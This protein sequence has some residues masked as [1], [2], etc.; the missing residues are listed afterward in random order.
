MEV[1][2]LLALLPALA[3]MPALAQA[4][5]DRPLVVRGLS[6]EGNRA[7]D[8]Y[9][10]EIS[11][12]TSVSSFA[13]RTGLVRWIGI[14][15]KRYFNETEFR[16]DV[17]RLMLL[18][19]QSGYPRVH[20]DTIVRRSEDAVNIRFL[21]SEG[22]PIVVRSIDIAG[23]GDVVP[24]RDLLRDIPLAVGDPFNRF[25]FDASAD[26]IRA[27]FRDRGHPFAEVFRSFDVDE[28]NLVARVAFEV[29]PG[30]RAVV[31]TVLVEG[32]R[33]IADEVVRRM[34]P[35]RS[36]ALVRQSAL[37]EAQR[38]LY[39][40]GIF[41][42]VNVELADS[43]PGEPEDS[44]VAVR[45]QVSEGALNRVRI[46]AGYGTIDCFRALTSFTAQN[47]LG[48]GRALDLTAR[49]SK[50]GVGDPF[51][52]GLERRLLCQALEP[53]TASGRL[54]LNYNVSL[55]L[56]TPY[57]FSRRTSATLSVFAERHSEIQAYVREVVGGNLSLT[58]QTGWN[59]PLTLTYSLSRGSTEAEPATFCSF[60]LVCNLDDTRLFTK[61][62]RQSTLAIA[63]RRERTNSVVDPTRGN[64]VSAEI[65][66]SSPTIGSDPLIDF[67]KGTAEFASY[68]PLGRR[69]TFAWRV[70]A[71]SI[72]RPG[73][74]FLGQD[75]KFVPPSERFYGGGPNSVRGYPQN[76]L[77]PLVRVISEIDT[78]SEQDEPLELDTLMLESPT[79]GNQV[80]LANAELRFPLPVFGGRFGAAVFADAGQVIERRER[81]VLGLRALRITPGI[82][83]RLATPLGPMRLDVAYNGY[84]PQQGRL[85]LP[86]GQQL[87]EV[88][89]SYPPVAPRTTFW[90]R[91]QW[92]FAVGPPF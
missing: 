63:L 4:P 59:V 36:G 15:D 13:A 3:G 76:G 69:S 56:R 30:S 61:P 43:L 55:S 54:D 91:L 53:D 17:L 35:I 83:I 25:L 42:Y 85:Y 86:E 37:Y 45:V 48:G 82:G 29:S 79:G 90:E 24:Q 7:I 72:A 8:N 47:A 10:L 77:G 5:V 80:I 31:D 28:V 58:Q 67:I 68:H 34:I 73:F 50:I 60:L 2:R 38:E 87:T 78:V 32:T 88:S 52:L 19:K 23:T 20:V 6:F 9:T 81:E 11:I 1:R 40:L 57:L 70:R 18:Y 75:V 74:V 49:A 65:R 27:A 62:L 39:R 66:Y 21:I 46:G 84:G 26:T 33:K 64:T 16:R 14:G 92:H 44:T 71:G 41:N 12:A 51:A 22:P 89:A